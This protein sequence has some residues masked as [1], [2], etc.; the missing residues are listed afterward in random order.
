MELH[1]YFR[2][3][4]RRWWIVLVATLV[5]LALG[6]ASTELSSSAGVAK[7]GRTY[8]KA[9]DTLIKTAGS[10]GG[11]YPSSVGTLDQAAVLV[12]T[13]PVPDAAAKT[14]G[15]GQNGRQLAEQVGT[16]TNGTS[17][18][19]AITAIAATPE[20]SV[21]IADTF[22]SALLTNIAATDQAQFT[23]ANKDASDRLNA[24]QAK[25]DALLAQV[26]AQPPGANT[27]LQQAQLRALNNQYS[28]AYDEF[29]SISSQQPP[30]SPLSVLAKAEAVP[31]SAADYN[32]RLARG[33]LGQNNLQAG[34][35]STA[36]AAPTSSSAPL[37]SKTT[38]G[39]LGGLFGFLAGIGIAIG[40]ERL[41]RR[42]R[43]RVDAEEAYNLPV[44]AEVPELSSQ[45]VDRHEIVSLSQPLSGTAEAFRTVRSSLL[46]QWSTLGGSPVLPSSRDEDVSGTGS[47]GPLVLMVT[48]ALPNVGK[49]TSTANLGVVFAEAGS[50][51]LV[52]NCDFR[53]PKLHHFFGIPNEARRVHPTALA[54]LKV[55]TNVLDETDPN[56]AR[57]V[58]AQRQLINAARDKF[59]VIILDTAPVLSANDVLEV[60]P[61]ID[62]VV[63]V[64][65]AGVSRT[66]AAHRAID[67]LSR[68]EAPLVGVVLSGTK[69]RGNEYYAYYHSTVGGRAAPAAS[70]GAGG[71]NGSTRD[72][73]ASPLG[74]DSVPYSG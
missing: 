41:D 5:G 38:R 19:L 14:L 28:S 34:A 33:Q 46:F 20:E 44:L 36:Q 9:T 32:T 23:Q 74:S 29:Q 1:S 66:P 35:P 25:I 53:R 59:D 56:P 6:V 52:L 24:I 16:L 2:A 21:T 3:L 54:N 57:V 31:I 17:N 73:G 45:Q 7:A 49:S 27:D 30:T 15:N 62:L 61:D 4:R 18:T 48:S 13:G 65:R 68:V 22:A 43:T 10:G 64:A 55:V 69:E 50:R 12:T 60:M 26:Q 51:T 58:A 42:I 70:S 40:L 63:V 67:M 71:V 72:P 8:Y 11:T 37:E 39:V 47:T